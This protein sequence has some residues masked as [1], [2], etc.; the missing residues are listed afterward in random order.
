M[1]EEE[2]EEPDIKFCIEQRPFF[3]QQPQPLNLVV[4]GSQCF[5]VW[6][7]PSCQE[8]F[9]TCFNQSQARPVHAL[10]CGQ[11]VGYR[12]NGMF[13]RVPSPGFHVSSDIHYLQK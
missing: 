12:Y 9:I 6:S 5:T 13:F 8:Y 11:V 3:K 7:D 1:G 4:P 10:V 2:E